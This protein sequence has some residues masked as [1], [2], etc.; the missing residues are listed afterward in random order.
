MKSWNFVEKEKTIVHRLTHKIYQFCNS[1]QVRGKVEP[2]N[3]QQKRTSF[4]GEK[5]W[6][7]TEK[8]VGNEAVA[9]L[10]NSTWVVRSLKL[11]LSKFH[12]VAICL[13]IVT[14]LYCASTNSKY[15]DYTKSV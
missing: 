7:Q 2:T 8:N 12:P 10:E 5:N 15:R 3:H 13:V 14:G 9:P 4:S 11:L 6:R 1:K